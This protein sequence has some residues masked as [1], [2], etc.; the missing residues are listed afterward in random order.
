MKQF[1]A[2]SGTQ[3]SPA[4]IVNCIDA[5]SSW[6]RDLH[7]LYDWLVFRGE[8]DQFKL[9]FMDIMKTTNDG[10]KY[11]FMEPFKPEFTASLPADLRILGYPPV[12][13]NWDR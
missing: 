9:K 3:H 6:L 2:L 7:F 8:Y 10:T 11:P 13:E 12:S 5:I 1:E 4:K